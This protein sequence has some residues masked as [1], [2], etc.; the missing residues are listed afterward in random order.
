MKDLVVA[1]HV[2]REIVDVNISEINNHEYYT[3]N[4]LFSFE[5]GQTLLIGNENFKILNMNKYLWKF[6]KRW[7]L[8]LAQY[9]S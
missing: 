4:I 3:N 7:K 9:C 1:S 6:G 2:R 8:D 5:V